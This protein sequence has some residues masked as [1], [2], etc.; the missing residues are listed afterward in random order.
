MQALSHLGLHADTPRASLYVWF[1]VPSGQ[2][3]G[4]FAARVLE[5]AHVSLAPGSIF[6]SNGEGYIR[7]SVTAPI[8]RVEEAMLRLDKVART[9]VDHEN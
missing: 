1:R 2:T 6:G 7:L 8:E 4:A 5:Q 3:S 9:V